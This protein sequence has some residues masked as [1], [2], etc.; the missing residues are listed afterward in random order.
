MAEPTQYYQ[1]PVNYNTG[2]PQTVFTE[3]HGKFFSFTYRFNSFD[4]S[5]ILTWRRSYDGKII[6]QGKLVK[7]FEHAIKDPV[8][9]IP[10]VMLVG[11]N[12]EK[13]NIE[14]LIWAPWLN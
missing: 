13:S 3:I 1:I 2:F 11:N 9:G 5:L 14:V 12:V 6:F 7:D 8:F 10:M 4:G